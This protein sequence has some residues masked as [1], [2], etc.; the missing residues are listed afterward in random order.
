MPPLFLSDHAGLQ[1]AARR[2]ANRL[3]DLHGAPIQLQRIPG[4]RDR[5]GPVHA[6]SFLRERRIAFDCTASEFP[7]IFIHELFHFAWIRAGNARRWSFEALV[8]AEFRSR[9]RGE[10]G[11]SAE[12]RK[13][14]LDAADLRLRTRPWRD[15]CCES[16]CDTAAWMYSGV[17]RHPEFTLPERYRKRRRRWFESEM[18]AEGLSI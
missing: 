11:W 10:L 12:W 4:L 9:A 5:R 17:T 1:D 14:D 6:G 13:A 8:Q 3:P 16:F 7:R 18:A 15:Y 2:I